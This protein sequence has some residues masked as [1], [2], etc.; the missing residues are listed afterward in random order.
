M[1]VLGWI[2]LGL[3]SGFVA[4]K[5]V[6][7]QGEGCF[8]NIALGLVGAMVGGFIFSAIGGSSITGFNLYSMLVAIVGAIVALLLWHAI[9]GRRTLR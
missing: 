2:V 6:N 7:D 1:S 9:T 8:L 3:I 4:S 5:V